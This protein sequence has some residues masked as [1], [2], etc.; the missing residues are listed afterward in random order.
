M[1]FWK[2][3]SHLAAFQESLARERRLIWENAGGEN[4]RNTEDAETNNIEGTFDREPDP[5][6]EIQS[7]TRNSVL[8]PMLELERKELINKLK[9]S[10]I[11]IEEIIGSGLTHNKQQELAQTIFGE[12]ANNASIEQIAFAVSTQK[13]YFKLFKNMANEALESP[14]NIAVLIK[15]LESEA[16]NI[17]KIQEILE[18]KIGV[19]SNGSVILQRIKDL[20][21]QIKKSPEVISGEADYYDFL[22]WAK[23]SSTT[24][25]EIRNALSIHQIGKG[26]EEGK[27]KLLYR[28]WNLFKRDSK[29]K[30]KVAR[31]FGPDEEKHGD[32]LASLKGSISQLKNHLFDVLKAKTE[33]VNKKFEERMQTY[34]EKYGTNDL[35][36]TAADLGISKEGLVQ[37]ITDAG[38]LIKKARGRQIETNQF[39]Q[40]AVDILTQ[41]SELENEIELDDKKPDLGLFGRERIR[42][43]RAMAWAADTARRLKLFF[44]KWKGNPDLLKRMQKVFGVDEEE[45]LKMAITFQET[46]DLL[47]PFAEK[48]H[49]EI[50]PNTHDLLSMNYS[51]V[52]KQRN[53]TMCLVTLENESVADLIISGNETLESQEVP[54]NLNK[55]AQLANTLRVRSEQLRNHLLPNGQLCEELSHEV[56]EGIGIKKRLDGIFQNIEKK[57][58][59]PVYESNE[60]LR[61]SAATL[62][63]IEKAI[64]QIEEIKN[65]TKVNYVNS[66]EHQ[67]I[68]DRIKGLNEA[69][70]YYSHGN[71]EIFINTDR[72]ISPE[73]QSHVLHHETGHAII[74]KFVRKTSL[75]PDLLF[76]SYNMLMLQADETGESA[77]QDLKA[78][79]LK[80]KIP[81]R[82]DDNEKKDLLMDELW[83]RYASWIHEGRK[84]PQNPDEYKKI[85]HTLFNLL[86]KQR[87]KD[88]QTAVPKELLSTSEKG[89]FMTDDL[90]ADSLTPT[91][92]GSSSEVEIIN[93]NGKVQEIIQQANIAKRFTI[94]YP[95][96]P[97]NGEIK[98]WYERFM[99][100]LKEH[101]EDPY[102]RN[103]IDE[104]QGMSR[105]T[106]I[107]K[108]ENFEEIIDSIIAFNKEQLLVDNVP[109]TGKTGLSAFFDGVTFLSIMDIVKA[110]KDGGEDL[111]RMWERSS[112]AKRNKVGELITSIIPDNNLWFL[113]AKYAGQLKHE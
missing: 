69:Q 102:L 58:S 49:A 17:E 35:G 62:E 80:W 14:E 26:N 85:E 1:T 75:F 82:D 11:A 12:K 60:L 79:E 52:S 81:E 20:D 77:L 13:A 106:Q 66:K 3:F 74:D 87:S 44:E 88:V 107:K 37:V 8:F 33:V 57:C 71:G 50:D 92:R 76:K 25:D 51:D 7:K 39:T 64:N 6:A 100:E 104:E 112:Q 72:A 34:F 91:S 109:N 101:I 23:S 73:Q 38:I 105:L 4:N 9:K 56:S 47:L 45:A 41:L 83:V 42:H 61:D 68:F 63:K 40:E 43:Q 29:I 111:K 15:S 78:L 46:R 31:E 84:V 55:R 86:E 32:T 10:P 53:M 103:N 89:M 28:V 36:A 2:P 54:E 24:E 90:D 93:L 18:G 22:G 70:G 99:K 94:S 48:P 110:V 95:S 108:D 97:Q 16:M 19:T 113:G 59:A 5:V 98:E 21:E 30:S 27:D 96:H 65:N 67:A